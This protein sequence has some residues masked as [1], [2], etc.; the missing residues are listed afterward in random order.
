MNKPLTSE[1]IYEQY[2]D[3]ATALIMDQYAAA[4]QKSIEAEEPGEDIAIPEALDRKCRKLIKKELARKHRKQLAKKALRF[5]RNIAIVII[6]LFGVA[7]ILFATVEAIRIPIIN[8]FIEQKEGYLEITGSEE[9]SENSAEAN[10]SEFAERNA[11]LKELLPEGY[12]QVA[13][14]VSSTG[15]ASTV[16]AN[17]AGDRIVFCTNSHRGILH[18]DTEGAAFSEKTSVGTHEAILIEKNGCHLAWFDSEGKILYQLVSN[19][20]SREEM[21]DLANNLEK[22]R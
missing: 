2:I 5:T 8:F 22:N 10:A 4:I 9:N 18:L 13:N 16:Y 6:M 17:P 15:N 11:R 1:E 19:S 12:V 20:M 14:E 7:G 3:A 21:I